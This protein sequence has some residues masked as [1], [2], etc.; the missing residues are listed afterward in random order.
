MLRF[1]FRLLITGYGAALFAGILWRVLGGGLV[2]A[3]LLAWI[4]GAV[5][6]LAIAAIS[7]RKPRRQPK[8]LDEDDAALAASLAQWE[9]DRFQDAPV[10]R[11]AVVGGTPPDPAA[12]A[13]G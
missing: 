7:A 8:A 10:S 5:F 13:R 3:T 6:V 12:G 2:L 4:G 1:P 11:P 9:A